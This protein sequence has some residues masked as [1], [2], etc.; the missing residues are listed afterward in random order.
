MNCNRVRALPCSP[1]LSAALSFYPDGAQHRHAHD[2]G[3]VSFLLSGQ[4]LERHGAREWTSSGPTMGVKQAGMA[5]ENRWGTEGVLIFSVNLTGEELAM[6][7]ATEPGW[8]GL[9]PS[10][11]TGALVRACI[12]APDAPRREEAIAD[13][14]ALPLLPSA[15]RGSPPGWLRRAHEAIRDDAG[16]IRIDSAAAK[17]GVHRVRFSALFR[18]Y[19]GMPPSLYRQR[20]MTAQAIARIAGSRMPLTAIA[21]EAGFSDQAHLTR[22]VSRAIG[23]GPKRLRALLR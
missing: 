19:Y 3:Q 13:M 6:L 1:G 5:H 14:L 7:P 20:V 11:P 22:S 12:E 18:H 17:A 2:F 9:E 8:F 23:M 4:M 16:T 10:A 15:P 21:Y